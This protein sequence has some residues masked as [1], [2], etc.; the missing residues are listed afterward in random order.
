MTRSG[1]SLLAFLF[2]L[3][4]PPAA[5]WSAAPT[6]AA[7]LRTEGPLIVADCG[8]D[9]PH[10]ALADKVADD[11]RPLR[12][13]VRPER[14]ACSDL[15]R[16]HWDDANVVVLAS[17]P[18]DPVLL[19]V[20]PGIELRERGRGLDVAG[21]R[22]KGSE[23]AVALS[24]PH[25]SNPRRWVMVLYGV[26]PA[27]LRSLDRHIRNDIAASALVVD[28]QGERL[29]SLVDGE[30]GW[31]VYEGHPYEAEEVRGRFE[32]WREEEGASVSGW[33]M[34]VE[35]VGEGL[36]VEVEVEVEGEGGR[37][38]G[39]VWL[40][41]TARAEIVSCSDACVPYDAR[42]GRILVHLPEAADA[43]RVSLAYRAPFEGVLH[44]WHVGE[45]AGY[46]M[47]EANWFPRIRGEADEPYLARGPWSVELDAGSARRVPVD[48]GGTPVL[49]WGVHQRVDLPGGGE[50]YLPPGAVE[51]VAEHA[52]ELAGAVARR[53]RDR[54]VTVV[55]VE[56]PVAWY[57]GGWLLAPPDLLQPGPVDE[58]ESWHLDRALG[59]ASARLPGPRGRERTYKGLMSSLHPGVT[60][61]L[62]RLR[63]SWWQLLDEG[64]VDDDGMFTLEGKGHGRLLITASAPSRAPDVLEVRGPSQGGGFLLQPGLTIEEVALVCLRC[65]PDLSEQRFAMAPVGPDRYQVTLQMGELFREYGS[66]PYAFELNP[67]GDAAVLVPDPRRPATQFPSFLSPEEFRA[68]AVTFELDTTH[69]RFWIETPGAMIAPQGWLDTR[70]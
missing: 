48:P 64:A 49:V 12:G 61:R 8:T 57:G 6:L 20:A 10:Q 17:E 3:T 31:G 39:E 16:L 69:L 37:G 47:P 59:E 18:T 2:L 32:A 25:P 63:G 51:E 38:S 21:M 11:L 5:A 24:L 70:D 23:V 45:A 14:V 53:T 54:D 19:A 4:M 28:G 29:A 55:A 56:R 26:T 65:G 35:V 44:A 36:E 41:L 62:W 60:V 43:G 33:G 50:A 67:G 13:G 30:D 7:A 9:R 40:Q 68:D 46:V 42:D 15:D 22:L 34:Q 27:A 1:P 52:S 58:L 66:F